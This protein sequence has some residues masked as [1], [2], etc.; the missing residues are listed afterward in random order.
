[1]EQQLN[2]MSLVASYWL[3]EIWRAKSAIKR[4]LNKCTVG[5]YDALSLDY[6]NLDFANENFCK[7]MGWA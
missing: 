4:D 5:N 6:F 1:M 3:G 2:E 7:E